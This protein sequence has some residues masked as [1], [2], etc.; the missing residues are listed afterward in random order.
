MYNKSTEY[1]A[2]ISLIVVVTTAVCRAL[3]YLLPY[4]Y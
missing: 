3:Y 2:Q 1:I 4:N